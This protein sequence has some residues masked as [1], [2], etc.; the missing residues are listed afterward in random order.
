M[1]M[2]G[3]HYQDPTAYRFF[4]F[5]KLRGENALRF[6][7][8]AEML[9]PGE[10]IL[11]V[12][13]GPGDLARFLPKGCRYTA[14]DASPEFVRSVHARGDRAFR[15]NLQTDNLAGID[16]ADAA[17]MLISLCQFPRP[18]IERILR[19]LRMIATR[20]LI[21][22]EVRDPNDRAYPLRAKVNDY[23]CARD[24][25]G[26]FRLMNA[27]TFEDIMQ[28]NGYLYRQLNKRYVLGIY[29]SLQAN[30]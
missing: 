30:V 8:A 24:F 10:K 27:R 21:I 17:I 11:D 4:T 26:P 5:L 19:E 15:R 25:C 14:V 7:L 29:P 3:L 16:P 12:C 1:I 18:V 28:A 2:Q 20:V 23:L 13:S 9:K 22:E 6:Q